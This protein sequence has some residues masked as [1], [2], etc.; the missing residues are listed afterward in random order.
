MNLKRHFAVLGAVVALVAMTGCATKN[1]PFDYTDYKASRPRSILVLPPVNNSPEVQA[2]YSMLSYATLPLAEAGYYVLP[3]TLVA[4]AFKENGMTQPTDMHATSADKL[5]QI[6][7]ADAALYITISKYGTTY[8][9]ITSATV[10]S[11]EAKLVDLKT[12]KLL[13]TGA[14]TASSEEGQSQGQG[15]LAGLLISA[16]VKQV[17]A[18]A[19]DQ[20]HRIAGVTTA[21][22]LSPGRPNGMLYGPRSPNYGKD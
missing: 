6:F 21:R 17:M 8:Q 2:T 14:D 3:V 9:V 7:G 15:S 12:G 10:V 20:G 4:E 13:W 22:L 16:I 19:L 11:A 5:R 1:A 18:S